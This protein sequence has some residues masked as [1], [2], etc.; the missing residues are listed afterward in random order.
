MAFASSTLAPT[1]R[2]K[3]RSQVLM[4]PA[5]QHGAQHPG[6]LLFCYALLLTVGRCSL[7]AVRLP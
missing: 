1:I 4:A 7:L 5:L 2:S 6:I 3:S